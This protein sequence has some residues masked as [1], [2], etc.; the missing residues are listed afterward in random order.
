MAKFIVD[1]NAF[2]NDVTFKSLFNVASEDLKAKQD[3]ETKELKLEDGKAQFKAPVTAIVVSKEG[4]ER[5]DTNIGLHIL[6]PV[7]IEA[8]V[9]Y[10]L[11]GKVRVT[12]Y[13][14]DGGEGRRASQGLSV[15]ADSLVP[16]KGDDQK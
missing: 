16:V 7:N 3:Y 6:N 12:P 10:K 2:N 11:A 5:A 14:I 1:G 13:I 8:G 15:I 9:A 4:K